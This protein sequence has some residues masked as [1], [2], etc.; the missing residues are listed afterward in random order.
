MA[1]TIVAEIRAL[2]TDLERDQGE[3]S[4]RY[5]VLD[6][7]AGYAR[8]AEVYDQLENPVIS[9]ESPVVRELLAGLPG[10]PILDAACGTGRYVEWLASLGRNV[11]GV[12]RSDAMVARARSKV[13]DAELHVGLLEEPPLADQCVAGVLCSLALDHVSDL[14][15]VFAQFQRVLRPG[16]WVL[17]TTMHPWMRTICG[18]TAWFEDAEGRAEVETN[19]LSTADYLNAASDVGLVL[20]RAVEVPISKAAAAAMAPGPT[21]T[22]STV[23][24]DGLPL[25][26]VLVFSSPG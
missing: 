3:N 7:D 5:P 18:W 16:G 11:I 4:V 25:I 19:R 22:A 8:W 26:L 9:H 2:L 20:R 17:T 6:A 1:D 12:D 10:E 14:S 13:P 21:P 23:A 24:L 15:R